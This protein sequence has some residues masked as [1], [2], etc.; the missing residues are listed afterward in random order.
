MID[1][2]RATLPDRDRCVAIVFDA[3]RSYG[4]EPE[5]EGLDADVMRFGSGDGDAYEIVAVLDGAIAGV[6]AL[7]P[8]GEGIGWVSKVF[9]DPPFRRRGA[10]RAL[11]AAVVAE[12][13]AR[14]YRRIGLQTR[15]IFREAVALYES[16]GWTRGDAPK[17]GPCDRTYFLDL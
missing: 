17:T 9:V 3:L 11:M 6:S 13:R 4:I 16:S 10:A 15:T 5:P 2:R 1:V 12:A 7:S 8:R 14:G